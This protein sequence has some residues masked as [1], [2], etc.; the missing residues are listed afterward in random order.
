MFIKWRKYTWVTISKHKKNMGITSD[1]LRSTCRKVKVYIYVIIIILIYTK[2]CSAGTMCVINVLF[3]YITD[4]YKKCKS[5][6]HKKLL[7]KTLFFLTLVYYIVYSY[8]AHSTQ[9]F[10]I[11]NYILLNCIHI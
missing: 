3:L 2:K 11:L 8:S 9:Q 1:R 4:V 7:K 10:I 6:I 5:V